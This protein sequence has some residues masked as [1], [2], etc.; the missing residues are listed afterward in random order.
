VALGAAPASCLLPCRAHAQL[1]DVAVAEVFYDAATAD[2]ELEWI[3]LVNDGDQ[4]VDLSSWSLGWG[5]TTYLSGV[6]ALA[7]MIEP[8]A[9]IVVGG[10]ISS[11]DN[12]SPVFHLAVDLEPDLQNS[13]AVADGVALFDVP[14]EALGTDSIPVSVVVYGE[15]N[16]S[17]LLDE[18]GAIAAVDVDDAPAGSSVERGP[19]GA[20]RVQPEPTP[21][22]APRAVPEPPHVALALV[23]GGALVLLRRQVAVPLPAGEH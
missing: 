13:G 17:G 7:G 15:E 3:E 19:D 18:T 14:V 11:A 5:G 21:G 20:W 10:P 9:R 4:P 1:A 2:D 12:A 22:A 8:G 16:E 6:Q 23:G